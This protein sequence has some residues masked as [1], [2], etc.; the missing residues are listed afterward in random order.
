[1]NDVSIPELERFDLDK[2]S[3]VGVITGPKKSKAMVVSPSGKMHIVE[4]DVHIGTRH[5]F[6]K[7]IVP[8]AISVEEKV[9]NLLGQEEKVETVI[10]FKE[11]DADKKKEG[12]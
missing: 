10:Q 5:G 2:W 12:L 1:M 9:V 8:G 6:I 4:E 3:L 7:K 11:K